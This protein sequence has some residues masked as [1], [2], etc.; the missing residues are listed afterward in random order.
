MF[1]RILIPTDG[2]TLARK[3]VRAGIVL[4]KEVG[5]S[6]VGYYAVE[7]LERLYYAEGKSVR[8]ASIKALQKRLLEQGEHFL[9]EIATAARA[10]GVACE[11]V[12]TSPAVPYQGIINAARKNKCDVIFMASHGRGKLVSLLLGSVTQK[13][14]THST[15]P[16][17]VY[18]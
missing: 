2:S 7:T 14:L 13:V 3:A 18:R 5:A 15:I 16:V 11:T 12:M 4:A 17:L 9:V 1:R 10:T 6:V 8:P